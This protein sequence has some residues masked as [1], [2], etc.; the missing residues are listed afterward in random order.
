MEGRV[1]MCINGQW[2]IV[3]DSGWGNREAAV[4]CRQLGYNPNSECCVCGSIVPQFCN[5]ETV[6]SRC[7]GSTRHS[8]SLF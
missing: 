8:A 1:E 3:C 5:T 7:Y 6:F 2:G 4:V